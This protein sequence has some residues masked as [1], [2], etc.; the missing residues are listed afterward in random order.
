[1][2]L[3]PPEVGLQPPSNEGASSIHLT[4]NPPTSA[5]PVPVTQDVNESLPLSINPDMCTTATSPIEN[6]STFVSCTNSRDFGVMVY[7]ENTESYVLS[8]YCLPVKVGTTPDVSLCKFGERECIVHKSNLLKK[9]KPTSEVSCTTYTPSDEMYPKYGYRVMDTRMV[10][11]FYPNCINK[12]T[13]R[14]KIFH[15]ACFMHSLKK[16]D[17]KQ[18]QLLKLES[19]DD[20]LMGYIRSD[21]DMNPLV[22]S[23]LKTRKDILL[24]VCGK[25]CYNWVQRYRTESMK[26]ADKY[27]ATNPNWDKD[28]VDGVSRCSSK[29]LIDWLTTEGNAVSYLGGSDKD[30]RTSS[31]RKETYHNLLSNMIK[32]E[33]SKSIIRL[34]CILI[35]LIYMK[36][37]LQNT[38]LIRFNPFS[39][40]D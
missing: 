27:G 31:S 34:L 20:K 29:V 17:N 1:M 9:G 39:R 11:C 3:P 5:L 16:V 37:T 26:E 30:G 7:H 8:Q 22:K 38:S 13:N 14:D 19:T 12:K 35:I 25:R 36:L 32:K 23:L 6:D 28:G 33:N 15:Y 10:K 21:D 24:P 40:I 4:K 2:S 18:M